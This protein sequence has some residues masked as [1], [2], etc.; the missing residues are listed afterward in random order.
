MQLRDRSKFA[1]SEENGENRE[2][3]VAEQSTLNDSQADSIGQC[4]NGLGVDVPAS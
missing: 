3:S 1:I 2:A 4:S